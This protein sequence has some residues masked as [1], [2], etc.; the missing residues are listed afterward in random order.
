MTHHGF[1]C[2]AIV[3]IDTLQIRWTDDGDKDVAVLATMYIAEVPNESSISQRYRNV[4]TVVTYAY[5]VA[6]ILRGDKQKRNRSHRKSNCKNLKSY[7]WSSEPNRS[8]CKLRV[9]KI[10]SLVFF[11]YI[12]FFFSSEL[13]LFLFY[14]TAAW[15]KFFFS[16]RKLFFIMQQDMN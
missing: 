6:G 15:S 1:S 16:L 9:Q 4:A 7:G 5:R 3:T 12:L 8:Q 14:V 11:C 10:N 13:P 2:D